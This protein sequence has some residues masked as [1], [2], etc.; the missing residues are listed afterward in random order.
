VEVHPKGRAA[1][2][3]G[4]KTAAPAAEGPAGELYNLAE[5][6]G[7]TKDLAAANPETARELA[8]LLQRIVA[9]GRSRP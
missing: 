9:D 2:G 7:E 4:K 5:D 1:Q 3:K 8:D 6:I